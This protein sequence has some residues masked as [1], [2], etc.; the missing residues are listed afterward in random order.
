MFVDCRFREDTV[1]LV[2]FQEAAVRPRAV[3]VMHRTESSDGWMIG[4]E[5]EEQF[6]EKELNVLRQPKYED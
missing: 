3:R 6:T 1:L 4:C 2:E 5:L